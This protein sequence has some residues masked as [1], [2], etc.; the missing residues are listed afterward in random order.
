[1]RRLGGERVAD[2]G[3]RRERNDADA[4]V[5]AAGRPNCCEHVAQLALVVEQHS[6]VV[7]RRGDRDEDPQRTGRHGDGRCASAAED[8]DE[9]VERQRRAA[10]GIRERFPRETIELV[11]AG[12]AD[13][14]RFVAGL[15]AIQASRKRRAQRRRQERLGEEPAR[16]LQRDALG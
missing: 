8:P 2:L 7:V 3:R 11:A 6:A 4:S 12:D 16:A 9:R 14:Q 1:M 5:A 13:V 15:G 10:A